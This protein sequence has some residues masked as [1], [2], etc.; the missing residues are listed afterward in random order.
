MRSAG[1]GFHLGECVGGLLL[2]HQSDIGSDRDQIFLLEIPSHRKLFD[3]PQLTQ[4]S[5]KGGIADH[6]SES[7]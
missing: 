3:Y 1:S 4:I 6:S 7:L 5:E 2:T